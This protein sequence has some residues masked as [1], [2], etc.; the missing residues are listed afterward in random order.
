MTPKRSLRAKR[1]CY[2]VNSGLKEL[3]E[4]GGKS[5]KFLQE[6]R[7]GFDQFVLPHKNEAALTARAHGEIRPDDVARLAHNFQCRLARGHKQ[8]RE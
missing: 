7:G 8:R 5:G 4:V 3:G 2:I 6:F 1:G